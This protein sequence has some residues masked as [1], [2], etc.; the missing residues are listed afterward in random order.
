MNNLNEMNSA[1]V[2]MQLQKKIQYHC[3]SYRWRNALWHC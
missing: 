3:R 1:L 2:T